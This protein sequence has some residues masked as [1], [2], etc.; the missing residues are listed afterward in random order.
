MP[1]DP[2][3]DPGFL[4]NANANTPVDLKERHWHADLG[5]GYDIISGPAN[6]QIKFGL[7]VAEVW[8]KVDSAT[9][10]TLTCFNFSSDDSFA[11]RER[12]RQ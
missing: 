5:I 3:D 9:N 4:V 1:P 8:A 12:D 11:H 7:R 6:L 2:P 10:G